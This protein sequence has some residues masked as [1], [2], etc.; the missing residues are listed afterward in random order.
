MITGK[1]R[2][3][4]LDHGV[5]PRSP[6]YA[7]T[8][9]EY[10]RSTLVQNPDGTFS[11]TADDAAYGEFAANLVRYNLQSWEYTEIAR[12][13]LSLEWAE[14]LAAELLAKVEVVPHRQDRYR[15]SVDQKAR[16]RITHPQSLGAIA[17]DWKTNGVS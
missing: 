13:N 16:T 2:R 10:P 9:I 4:T 11:I 12:G 6:V 5:A 8:P 7:I 3:V 1:F 14:A 17:A 15:F